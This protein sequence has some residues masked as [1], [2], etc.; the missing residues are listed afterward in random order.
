M[1]RSLFGLV[2]L[3]AL[4]LGCSESDSIFDTGVPQTPST[5]GVVDT[6]FGETDTGTG[7]G[8]T[9]P[10]DT[11]EDTGT[12]VS[13]DTSVDTG[14]G[15][16]DV[17]MPTE[18]ETGS[19]ETG[20]DTG[21]VIEDTGTGTEIGGDTDS[22]TSP[23][24]DAGDMDGG[25]G[26][27]GEDTGVW[28]DAGICEELDLYF[29]R[30]PVQVMI[31]EDRSGSMGPDYPLD[32][33]SVKWEI[34]VTALS[35]LLTSYD[36]EIRFGL[37]VFTARDATDWCTIGT[38]V[39][40]DVAPE[41]ASNIIDI[42]GTITPSQGT[43]L[44]LA[45]Q[46]FTDPLYAPNL[47]DET[48]ESYLVIVSDGQD[49]CGSAGVFDTN[50]YLVSDE[51][52]AVTAQLL[53]EYG[54]R[55][56]VIGFGNGVDPDQL[57][58]ISAAGGTGRDTYYDAADSAELNAVLNDIGES[59][60]VTCTFDIGEYDEEDYNLDYV[61]ITFDDEK[62]PRDDDC[63]NGT[64]WTWTDNT[65]TGIQFCDAACEAMASIEEVSVTIACSL[66]DVPII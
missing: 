29:E 21:I 8:E 10:E 15:T 56:Y 53:S 42:L 61:T 41:N 18:T 26:D 49:T 22:N 55:T 52:A 40:S 25:V 5:V 11:G 19:G 50:G 16:A 35:D 9:D 24:G 3:I 45:L 58:A 1:N 30:R 20:T 51:L 38:A 60:V 31:L 36:T 54:I 34:A 65:R 32:D 27:G 47:V 44:L 33:G 28:V 7:V 62:I 13:E 48:M 2:S 57:N 66:D 6:G 39:V 14:T 63:A 23:E 59:V 12:G 64:G 4:F 43:P 17:E 46:N 37:D